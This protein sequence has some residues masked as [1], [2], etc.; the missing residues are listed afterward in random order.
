M[1]MHMPA[2]NYYFTNFIQ[3]KMTIYTIDRKFL[4]EGRT[5]NIDLHKVDD[6][7]FIYLAGNSGD[8]YSLKEF[9][10]LYNDGEID[11]KNSFIRFI[12]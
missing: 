6:E 5:A 3:Q 2:T 8:C 9:Q 4:T 12:D 1:V 7:T 10:N 11:Y